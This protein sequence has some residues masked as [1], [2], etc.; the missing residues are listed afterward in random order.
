MD[1]AR[2]GKDRAG[3]E[4]DIGNAAATLLDS[5]VAPMPRFLRDQVGSPL[6]GPPSNADHKGPGD[7]TAQTGCTAIVNDGVPDKTNDEAAEDSKVTGIGASTAAAAAE[8]EAEVVLTQPDPDVAKPCADTGSSQQQQPLAIEPQMP[9]SEGDEQPAEVTGIAEEETVTAVGEPGESCEHTN[10]ESEKDT[11]PGAAVVDEQQQQ[12]PGATTPTAVVTRREVRELSEAEV[13]RTAKA[14]LHMMQRHGAEE[15]SE[16][17]RVAGMHGYPGSW[18]HHAQ[19]TFPSWHRF[20]LVEFEQALRAADRALGNDGAIGCP[21]WDWTRE[22]VNGQ[23]IPALITRFFEAV[24]K[25]GTSRLLRL[26]LPLPRVPRSL[27]RVELQSRAVLCSVL[28]CSVLCSALPR[29]T[30]DVCLP[31]RP[32]TCTVTPL[33]LSWPPFPPHKVSHR[34]PRGAGSSVPGRAL[35]TAQREAA[36]L[37][38]AQRRGAW[39]CCCCCS[40]LLYFTACCN[41]LHPLMLVSRSIFGSSAPWWSRASGRRS[42][43]CT[44]PPAGEGGQASRPRTTASTLRLGGRCRLLSLQREPHRQPLSSS[45]IHTISLVPQPLLPRPPPLL[46]LMMMMI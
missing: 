27:S 14:L 10:P 29:S 41:A 36:G 32:D 42:I 31:W 6:V 17:F 1:A 3:G 11:P 44:P 24:P 45:A 2:R 28:C 38:S 20:F 26:L 4:G 40:P 21:Y 12:L 22:E 25:V 15:H 34:G 37:A 9:E 39:P 33:P 43:G 5:D 16:F 7:Q 13:E 30:S 35:R 19:E 8:N 23:V 18:C 46:L